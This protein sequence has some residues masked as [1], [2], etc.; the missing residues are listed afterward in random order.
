MFLLGDFTYSRTLCCSGPLDGTMKRSS[1]LIYIARI[2]IL[3]PID[4]FSLALLDFWLNLF[5]SF[6]MLEILVW[7]FRV[8]KNGIW[9]KN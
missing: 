5:Q 3:N 7:N 2:C 9:T 1:A 6:H 4:L 8:A